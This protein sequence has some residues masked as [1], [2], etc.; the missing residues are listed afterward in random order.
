MHISFGS[1]SLDSHISSSSSYL[2]AQDPYYFRSERRYSLARKRLP[3]EL[4]QENG[5]KSFP[6]TLQVLVV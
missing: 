1:K 2:L 3:S 6:S 5:A 4:I